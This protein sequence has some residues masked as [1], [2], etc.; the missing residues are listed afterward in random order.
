MMTGSYFAGVAAG[1]VGARHIVV[2]GR[3]GRVE[4]RVRVVGEAGDARLTLNPH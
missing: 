4:H 3:G 2:G 1:I